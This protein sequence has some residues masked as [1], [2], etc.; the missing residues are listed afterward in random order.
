MFAVSFLALAFAVFLALKTLDR[1]GR[2]RG[3]DHSYS[4]NAHI[5]FLANVINFEE[6]RG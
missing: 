4:L 5:H 1:L 2:G 6:W 3:R